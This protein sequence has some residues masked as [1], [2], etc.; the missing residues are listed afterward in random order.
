MRYKI[1]LLGQKDCLDFCQRAQN[2][3]SEVSLIS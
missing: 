1:E 3:V 2:I